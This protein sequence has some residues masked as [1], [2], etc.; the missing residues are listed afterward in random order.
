MDPLSIILFVLL[1]GLSAFFSWS[2]IA[3]MSLANHKIDSFVKQRKPGAKSLRL[4]R[5]N[6]DRLLILI[7]IWNNLVN[8]TTASLA[9]KISIDIAN[10]SGL[11]QALAIGISTWIITLLILL[12]W[13]IFPKTIATRYA[14]KIALNVARFYIVLGKIFYPIV[15]SVEYLM[16]LFQKKHKKHH[17]IT[18]EEIDSFIEMW[19][20]AWIFEKWEY[21]KIKNMLDFYEINAQ[22]VMTPRIKMEALPDT[23]TVKQAKEEFIKFSHSRIPIYQNTI[24]N[25][26]YFITLRDLLIA[27]INWWTNKMLKELEFWDMMKVPLT[28][29]IHLILDQFKKTRSH[30]ALVID[31]YWWVAGLI[32]LEDVVEEVFGEI[33]DETDKETLSIKKEWFAY[34]FQSHLT[35]DEFLKEIWVSFY[36]LDISEEEFSWETLSYFITSHLERFP[37]IG[38]EIILKIKQEDDNRNKELYLKILSLEKNTIGEIKTEIVKID[39]T[40]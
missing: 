23:L 6:S 29:P 32:T 27:E 7:L 25:I 39:N 24:D 36:D 21:E 8:I 34:I 9:T 1:F 30:V 20:K 22:E 19:D 35:M 16:N 12:F 26:D 28:K 33:M 5:K 13:E 37:K 15:I 10:N 38:E 2:E 40:K 3:F 18:D 4:L 11:E 31:E 14:E 17:I